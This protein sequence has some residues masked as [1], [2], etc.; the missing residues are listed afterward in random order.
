MFDRM[1]HRRQTLPEG[2]VCL[3]LWATKS[4]GTLDLLS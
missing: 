4:Q 3:R 1:V 2:L